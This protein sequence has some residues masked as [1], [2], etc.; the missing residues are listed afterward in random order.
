MDD[1]QF[2]KFLDNIS[3][4]MENVEMDIDQYI[5]HIH[6]DTKKIAPYVKQTGHVIDIIGKVTKHV[7]LEI[8]GELMEGFSDIYLA[9]GIK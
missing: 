6:I 7:E 2:H 4:D 5:H 3:N 9:D 8:A 1:S